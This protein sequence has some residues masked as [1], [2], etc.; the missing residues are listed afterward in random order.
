MQH[1][2]QEI[3][4]NSNVIGVEGLADRHFEVSYERDGNVQC[5][6]AAA[7]VVASGGLPVAKLGASDLA[8]RTARRFGLEVMPTAPALVPLAITGKDTDRKSTRLNSSH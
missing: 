6:Y 1:Y 8:L 5:A 4:L 7:V 3:L 2:K